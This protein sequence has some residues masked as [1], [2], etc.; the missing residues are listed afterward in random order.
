MLRRRLSACLL[1][2]ILS[3]FRRSHSLQD[4]RVTSINIKQLLEVLGEKKARKV[5]NILD[6]SEKDFDL[7][8]VGK[9]HALPGLIFTITRLPHIILTILSG[10]RAF[11]GTQ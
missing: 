6:L 3:F 4:L 2:A 1:F 9:Y 10:H 11:L 7:A 8:W 5:S